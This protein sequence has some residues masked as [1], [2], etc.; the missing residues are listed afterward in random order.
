EWTLAWTE[1]HPSE[2]P[3]V[4]AW[5][6]QGD[7]RGVLPLVRFDHGPLKMLRFPG[8]RRADWIEPACIHSDEAEMAQHCA[9]YLG[10]ETDWHV[11]RMDRLDEGSAWPAAVGDSPQ[12]ATAPVRRRDVLPYIEF[13]ERGYEGY[14]ADR[15][16]HF[17]SKLGN[18]RR[19]LERDHGLR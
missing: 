12:L 16:R 13:D 11:L 19:R 1:T 17:R 5:R 6:R 10:R 14:L 8:A 9:A 15:S 3:F 4:L 18:R 2:V 7:V